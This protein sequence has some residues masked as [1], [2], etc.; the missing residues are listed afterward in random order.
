MRAS[1]AAARRIC[2]LTA[3]ALDAAQGVR[4]GRPRAAATAPS[5]LTPVAKAFSTDLANEVTSLGVQVHGGMGFIE[6][7]GRGAAHARRPHPRRST[8]APTASRRID[9]VARKLPLNGGATV[10]SQIAW[11]RRAA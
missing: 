7:T 5:L 6:E 8:R 4:S 11:M 10:R 3:A 9:L 1:T 2:Y